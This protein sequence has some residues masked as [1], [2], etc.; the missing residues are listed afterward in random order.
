MF[1]LQS[2]Y[3]A[4]IQVQKCLCDYEKRMLNPLSKAGLWYLS[5][6]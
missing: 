4:G 3:F 2:Y 1:D 5:V 6:S